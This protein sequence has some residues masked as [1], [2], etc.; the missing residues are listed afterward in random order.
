MLV[1]QEFT[2]KLT[3]LPNILGTVRVQINKFV[4]DTK[5]Q[6][7]LELCA[8]EILANIIEYAY[9]KEAGSVYVS[10]EYIQEK[11]QIQFTF[12]DN[13]IPYNPLEGISDE[14]KNPAITTLEEQAIGGLGIFLYTTIMDGVEYKYCN[15]KNKLIVWKNL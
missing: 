4:K 8:E 10:V 3:D 15:G 11:N 12:M 13:G 14:E 7:R 2:A 5:Q 1:E 9:P 6:N